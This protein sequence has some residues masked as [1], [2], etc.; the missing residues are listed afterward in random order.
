MAAIVSV[1]GISWHN[2][3][4]SPWTL[5]TTVLAITILLSIGF[6]YYYQKRRKTP[7]FSAG[8]IRR[9]FFTPCGFDFFLHTQSVVEL[10]HRR[11]I[12]S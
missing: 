3:N 5:I 2:S 8:D 1:F 11:G 7:R 12:M 9:G 6:D 4:G 10:N